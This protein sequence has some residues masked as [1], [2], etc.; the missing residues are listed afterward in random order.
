[1]AIC[2]VR[3]VGLTSGGHTEYLTT[4]YAG[5]VLFKILEDARRRVFV[6]VTLSDETS[7]TPHIAFIRVF[8]KCKTFVVSTV[9]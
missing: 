1:M 7:T 6:F 2:P 3:I 9:S 8:A 5:G 4:W